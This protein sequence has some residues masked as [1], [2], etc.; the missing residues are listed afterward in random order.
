MAKTTKTMKDWNGNLIPLKYVPQFDRE[1]DRVARRVL[2]RYQKARKVLEAVVADSLAEI[3]GLMKLKEKLGVKGNFQLQS[4]DGCIQVSIRQQ[5]NIML[6]ERVAR[7]RELMLDYVN[8][9][10]AEVKGVDVTV[11]RRLI[12]T[13]FRANRQGVLPTTKI[14]ELMRMEVEDARWN[15]ARKL[16]QDAIKP[17]RGKRYLACETRKSTQGDFRPISLN[18]NDC[19]PEES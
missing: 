6:D 14:F 13:A 18:L 19:W 11:L 9:I 17:Q 5:Y 16:L 2:E 15:E 12:E 8:G 4:F 10:L 3:D 7:A 1:R